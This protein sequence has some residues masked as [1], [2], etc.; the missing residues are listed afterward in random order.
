MISKK[1][2]Q[3]EIGIQVG[4][5]G[6]VSD[7]SS[8]SESDQDIQHPENAMAM[9]NSTT[10]KTKDSA[11]SRDPDEIA[12]ALKM[13]NL[14]TDINLFQDSIDDFDNMMDDF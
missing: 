10:C 4:V 1:P 2:R 7:E 5:G 6:T 14:D 13:L 8:G 12:E 11:T 9:P 3:K